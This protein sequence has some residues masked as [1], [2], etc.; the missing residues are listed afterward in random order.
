[1]MPTGSHT[2]HILAIDD[3]ARLQEGVREFLAP[4]GYEVSA[5]F[6]GR[7][8]EDHIRALSPD[9][10]LLDVMF[11]EDDG[12]SILRR[13]RAV[14]HVPVI[15][16]SARGEDFD[17]IFGLEQGAD[18][19]IAK[20]FNPQE[21]LARIRAVL[22]RASEKRK[23]V[24]HAKYPKGILATGSITLD[25]D[26]QMLKLQDQSKN[27]STSEFA[28]IYVFMRHAGKVLSRD[29]IL[30]LAFGSD[31]YVNDRSIDVHINRLRKLLRDLGD[32]AMRIRTVWGRGYTWV[33][34]G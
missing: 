22:R 34:R 25:C 17:R 18:D 10:V 12:F 4:S 31:Y 7:N 24:L 33:S 8:I 11:P 2:A 6:D 21:L 29:E 26:R 27:L 14:S 30:S 15:L 23:G 5:L 9:I 3:D 20:P 13:I 32:E 16:L 19:Y 1:M 28:V